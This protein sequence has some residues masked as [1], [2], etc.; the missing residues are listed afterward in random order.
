MLWWTLQQL[1]SK[2]AKTRLVAVEKLAAME[3]VSVLDPLLAALG[4]T[5]PGV[6]RLTV[7]A[8]G[9]LK[10]ERA[11]NPLVKALHDRDAAVREAAAEALREIGD[12]RAMEPLVAALKD[13]SSG[14]RWRAANSALSRR[15]CSLLRSAGTSCAGRSKRGCSDASAEARAARICSASN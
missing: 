9:K 14:V 3:D 2:D 15:K 7:S 5:D 4:D 8:L 10:D 11:A 1:K 13:D 12:K 6:R